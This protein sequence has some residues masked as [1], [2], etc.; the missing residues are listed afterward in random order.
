MKTAR[1]NPMPA[2]A[3][4]L[5]APVWP[6][7]QERLRKLVKATYVAHG[8]AENMELNDWRDLELELNRRLENEYQKRQQ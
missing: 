1:I 3:L 8:G 5:Y 4:T 7:L 6:Q 2:N